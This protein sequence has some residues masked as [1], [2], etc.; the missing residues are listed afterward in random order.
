[1]TDTTR[2]L[3]VG[4]IHLGRRPSRLPEEADARAL[5][6]AEAWRRTVELARR[7][8][9]AAVLLAG[10]VVEGLDDRFEAFGPLADGVERLVE[11]GID[12]LAVAGNHDVQALPRLARRLERHARFRLLG[13]GGVWEAAT[14]TPTDGPP[15][16]VLGW[17]F[18]RRKVRDSPLTTFDASLTP[19]DG[20]VTLGLLH[21]DLDQH[22]SEYAP[23]AAADLAATAVD[24]WLLGHVHAPGSPGR[25]RPGYL[26][27]LVGLD[28]GEHGRRG[29]WRVT[30][31]RAGELTLDHVPLGPLRYERVRVDA[32]G[33]DDADE[34]APALD[35]LL[36]DALA[37]RDDELLSELDDTQLVGVR[38]I[39]S[40]RSARRRELRALCADADL[41]AL[42]FSR[43][44][45]TYFVETLRDELRPA[46]D[47]AALADAEGPPGLLAR[48]LRALT[49]GGDEADALVAQARPA[50][51]DATAN[52]Y[53]RPRRGD[54]TPELDDDAVREHLLSA[55]TRALEEL[56]AQRPGEGVAP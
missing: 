53:L 29:P 22:A 31:D 20:T 26:G 30:V 4:D 34:L 6:P 54:A 35:E 55:G 38:L 24:A 33:L 45:T 40:G 47:L 10:D 49:D 13:Q 11:A 46:L 17:S 52:A 25:G 19:R 43:E 3:A 37:R 8:K 5:G 23:V 51:L 48:R 56:F 16:R 7:E 32:T 42:R 15:V 27:S 9:V 39:L 12:V 41:A 36:L 28:P 44:G 2:I 21:T 18:P 50:L 14:V 1:M